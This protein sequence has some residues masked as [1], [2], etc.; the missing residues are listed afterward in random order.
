[1]QRGGHPFHRQ[2]RMPR[3]TLPLPSASP[4]A[5]PPAPGSRRACAS[6]RHA[7]DE[8]AIHV[9]VPTSSARP[10]TRPQRVVV[11]TTPREPP[12][13]ARSGSRAKEPD[14][15]SSAWRRPDHGRRRPHGRPA[16]HSGEEQR[17]SWEELP[18]TAQPHLQ[19]QF[20]DPSSAGT[21]RRH[22]R[23]V[24]AGWAVLGIGQG[25][26]RGDCASAPA[27]RPALAWELAAVTSRM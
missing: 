22:G 14:P 4:A 23:G 7:R 16:P 2:S 21:A 24:R 10:Q 9:D 27:P 8:G 17:L 12:H 19:H 18:A 5:S 6:R 3:L 1:M 25:A 26:A 11:L 15:C 13:A 20:A